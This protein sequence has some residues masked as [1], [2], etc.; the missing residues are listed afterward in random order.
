MATAGAAPP[1]GD[2]PKPKRE[3]TPQQKRTYAGAGVV[4]VLAL[5]VAAIYLPGLLNG[6]TSTAP[7]TPPTASPTAK[8]PTG[9]PTT[10]PT[11]APGAAPVTAAAPGGAT[12]PSTVAQPVVFVSHSRVDPFQPVYLVPPLLPTPIPTAP[13]PQIAIPKIDNVGTPVS[14]PA[15]RD[16][17]VREAVAQPLNI[18]SPSI[19]HVVVVTGP[20]DAFPLPR[21]AGGQT[22]GAP[23]QSYDKRL[24]GVII[25]DGVRALLELPSGEQR[26][27]QPG[28]EVEGVRVLSIERTPQGG[29]TATRML[30]RDSDG[31]QKYVEL[32]PSTQAQTAGGPGG[33]GP[34]GPG[35]AGI[36][37]GGG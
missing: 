4:G 10:A 15:I 18:G 17:R 30:V 26:I 23:S 21:A 7:V 27:V 14:L 31:S 5:I 37:A 3:L 6:G 24:A 19:P 2:S 28:D 8:P 35:G 12:S 33:V 22:T 13:D 16:A 32:R 11:T 36:G 20:R 9:A 1:T 25:G 29:S 34:G